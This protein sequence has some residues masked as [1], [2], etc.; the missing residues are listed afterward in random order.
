MGRRCLPARHRRPETH[1]MAADRGLWQ[2]PCCP[3]SKFPTA[4]YHIV[5][6]LSRPSTARISRKSTVESQ[7]VRTF[8]GPDLEVSGASKWQK[9]PHLAPEWIERGPD[10]KAPTLRKPRRIGHPEIQ[11]RSLNFK[12]CRTRLQN[13][14]ALSLTPTQWPTL[15][16]PTAVPANSDGIV[17]VT[18]QLNNMS[19]TYLQALQA[20]GVVHSRGVETLGFG[21]PSVLD[22]VPINLCPIPLLT[23]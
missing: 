7:R 9:K 11:G 16:G 15:F 18:S 14:L 8:T 10:S 13:P 4:G 19:N 2:R 21:G 23:Y 22:A 20:T 5:T 3:S 6:T 17:P 12:S 1:S